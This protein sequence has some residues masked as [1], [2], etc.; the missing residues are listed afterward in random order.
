MNC[1]FCNSDRSKSEEHIIPENIGGTVIIDNVC[2]YCNSKFGSEVDIKLIKNRH[3]YD[4]YHKLNKKFDLDL[5]FEFK[6]SFYHMTDGIRINVS[7]RS[8]EEKT[9]VTKT[10]ENEFVIDD[11]NTTFIVDY[12]KSKGR[13]K[14]YLK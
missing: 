12:I 13:K 14:T 9:L 4:A 11:H 2:K 7:K 1:I 8:D 10:G 5:K 3:I 6:D